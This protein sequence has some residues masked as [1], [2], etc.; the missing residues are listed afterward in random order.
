MKLGKKIFLPLAAVMALSSFAEEERSWNFTYFGQSSNGNLNTFTQIDD[1]S[2][3]LNS[4]SY[5][6][7]TNAIGKKGGKFTNY[8]DGISY[9]YTVIDAENENFEL[10]ATVNVDYINIKPDGQEGFGI[11]AMDALGEDKVNSKNHYTNSASIIAWKYSKKVNDVKKEIKDGIGARFVSGI[12]PEVLAM[13]DSGIAQNG[14]VVSKAFS[15]NKA[16]AVKAGKTY[17]LTLKKDNTGYHAIYKRDNAE[18]E[19]TEYVMYDAENKKLRELDKEHIYVGF[20]VARGVNATFSDVVLTITDPKT[21]APAQPE[22]PELVPLTCLVASPTAY[23]A[24]K[25]PFVYNANSN[26][27]LTVVNKAGKVLINNEAITANVD[28][29]KQLKLASGE[30]ELTITFTPDS[31][32]KPAAKQVIAQYNDKKDDYEENYSAVT[33][34]KTITVKNFKGKSLYVSQEGSSEGNGTADSPLDLVSA[35]SFAKPNQKIVLAGGKYEMSEGVFIERGNSGTKKAYKILTADKNNRAILDFS[36]AK[37]GFVSYGDY[38]TIENIDVTKTQGNIKGM[39]IGGSYNIVR[40]VKTYDNGDTGLQISGNSADAKEKWP[41]DNLIIS[42]ESY[43]NSD[44]AMNNADGFAAKI[45]CREGNVFRYCIAYSN[46]DDG[47]DLFSKIETG[48]IGEVVID[49]CVAYKNGSLV[50][51]SGKG[52]G[53][54]FKMGGDGIAVKHV[55]KNSVSYANGAAGIT[56][57]SNPALILENVTSFANAGANIALYGKGESSPRL[58]SA[59]GVISVKGGEADN[60]A[61]QSDLLT[62]STYFFD[63]AKSVNANGDTLDESIFENTKTD[64]RPSFTDSGVIDLHGLLVLTDKA[65]FGAVIK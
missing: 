19:N 42:C 65:P 47:W 25:Y 11:I 29:T 51:G 4:C 61:E 10:S 35:L 57:N 38:W 14:K 27:K 39:Q 13:G 6:E 31:N 20:A 43:N 9:Y 48:P 5:N 46:I 22:P 44:P 49:S 64:V 62:A 16:N 36:K 55:L 58:F 33:Q 30:N 23:F 28:F 24:A 3:T 26:G 8:H 56:S 32:Y 34:V 60:Y 45:T 40:S 41:H 54:G 15:Y 63:G 21:D 1:K 18:G 12:T 2:F 53:N 52:D 7:E 37:A 50:D 17:R 59:T